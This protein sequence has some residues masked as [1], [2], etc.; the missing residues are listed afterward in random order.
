MIGRIGSIGL[1]LALVVCAAGGCD[2]AGQTKPAAQAKSSASGAAADKGAKEKTGEDKTADKTADTIADKIAVDKTVVGT[3]GAEVAPTEDQLLAAL[4]KRVSRAAK[5]AREIEKKPENADNILD[6]A[7]LDR[8]GFEDL[9]YT[10]GA[11]PALS[12]QYQLA[13]ADD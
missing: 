11:D 7:D 4:D 3:L 10:I 13:L 8:A 9:M 5:L 2:N 6:A 1:S 12:K